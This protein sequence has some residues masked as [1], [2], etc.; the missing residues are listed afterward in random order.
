MIIVILFNS[1]CDICWVAGTCGLDWLPGWV[2]TH[3]VEKTELEINMM[4]KPEFYLKTIR[5]FR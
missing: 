4:L 1:S 2:A 5:V 3:Y